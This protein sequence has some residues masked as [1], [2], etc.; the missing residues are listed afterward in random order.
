MPCATEG[1]HLRVAV[2]RA[3]I[4]GERLR[5]E[6][7]V[8]QRGGGGGAKLAKEGKSTRE[9]SKEGKS[10]RRDSSSGLSAALW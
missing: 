3:A 1:A 7:H 4:H 5:M 2:L 8:P 10:T 9:E 6:R